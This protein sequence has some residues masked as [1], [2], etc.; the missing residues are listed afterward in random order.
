M[1]LQAVLLKAM[2]KKL[3][4][5]RRDR[6]GM[7]VYQHAAQ[8]AGVPECDYTGLFDQ[9]RGNGASIACLLRSPE[10]PSVVIVNRFGDS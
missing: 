5:S 10:R 7:S 4:E 9:R 8:A 1:K 3:I 6:A 2:T